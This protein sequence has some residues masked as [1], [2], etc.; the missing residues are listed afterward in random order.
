MKMARTS[1]LPF[2]GRE[3]EKREEE[4]KR[5]QKKGRW[6]RDNSLWA[7]DYPRNQNLNKEVIDYTEEVVLKTLKKTELFK[8]IKISTKPYQKTDVP[9]WGGKW[10]HT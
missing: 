6:E 8:K 9:T 5:K 2:P 4:K 7:R 1:Q 3:E 10:I